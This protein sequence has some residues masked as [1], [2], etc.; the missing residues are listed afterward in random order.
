[1]RGCIYGLAVGRMP[2]RGRIQGAGGSRLC[3]GREQADAGGALLG[4]KCV[5]VGALCGGWGRCVYVLCSMLRWCDKR[6]IV[7]GVEVGNGGSG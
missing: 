5:S 6:W 2:D 3:G 4:W 1:M 7:A